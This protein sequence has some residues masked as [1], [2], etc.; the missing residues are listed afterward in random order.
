MIKIFLQN[1]R[2]LG[3]IYL[4]FT[5]S[6]EIKFLSQIVVFEDEYKMKS[7][8]VELKIQS[9]KFMLD[10][11]ISTYKQ[12]NKVVDD[13]DSKCIDTLQKYNMWL[14]HKDFSYERTIELDDAT[15]Y[16]LLRIGKCHERLGNTAL[17]IKYYN[18]T[19]RIRFHLQ[20]FRY[21]ILNHR[22]ELE[23]KLL[24]LQS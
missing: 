15:S 16:A 2:K 7:F 13:L 18:Q 22:K 4:S 9:I 11:F 17:A 6:T 19:V 1:K 12:N 5:D 10:A 20:Y 3:Y 23:L 21:E 8:I 14:N 24:L